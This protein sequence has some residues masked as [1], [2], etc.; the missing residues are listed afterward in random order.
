MQTAS[1]H[2]EVYAGDKPSLDL[3]DGN[4]QVGTYRLP[5]QDPCQAKMH[6]RYQWSKGVDSFVQP[7]QELAEVKQDDKLVRNQNVA[8]LAYSKPGHWE[9]P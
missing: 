3:P 6:E 9:H 5:L 8:S 2:K 4:L 1:T 7:K